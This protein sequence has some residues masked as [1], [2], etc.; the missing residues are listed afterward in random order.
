MKTISQLSR[1]STALIGSLA[2][3]K[4]QKNRRERVISFRVTS[5]QY[6]EIIQRCTNSHGELLMTPSDYARYSTFHQS[7]D[8]ASEWPLERY[9]MAIAAQLTTAVSDMV[10]AMDSFK[11]LGY[12]TQIQ[13]LDE[14]C[15]AMAGI[16]ADIQQLFNNNLIRD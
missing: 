9:R 7:M 12:E 14:V 16:Q 3:E 4:V 1:R 6:Q 2:T 13:R 5:D 11:M 8:Q 10:L 15:E